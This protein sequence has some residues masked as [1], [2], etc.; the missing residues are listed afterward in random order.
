MFTLFIFL[1]VLFALIETPLF[2]VIAG[3]SMV[4]LYFVD[5][6][7]LALQIILIEMNRLASMPVLVALPLF[8]FVGA[9]LTETKA[10]K[11]IMDLM[12]A[13]IGW[14]PGGLAIAALCA[15]AFFTALTG[16]SGVTIVAL[17]SVLYPVLRK[18]KYNETFT[19]GLLTTSGSRGFYFHPAF[20]LFCMAS[21]PKLKSLKFLKPHC[22]LG[23]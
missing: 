22:F 2:T 14:L 13:L 1:I 20:R 8:T 10:P 4:C 15:C 17:G 9:I 16:A 6:D 11:R 7:W 3:L 19:L 12:Q 21:L 23:F 18:R 5:F